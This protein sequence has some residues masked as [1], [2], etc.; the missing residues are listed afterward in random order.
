MRRLMAARSSFSTV[1]RARQPD[2]FGIEGLRAFLVAYVVFD[3]PQALVDAE[4]SVDVGVD[5]GFRIGRRARPS[6]LERSSV[7]TREHWRAFCGVAHAP[8]LDAQDGDF[9]E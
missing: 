5:I 3:H 2:E 1:N 8:R 9:V 6:F 4:Q 7:P